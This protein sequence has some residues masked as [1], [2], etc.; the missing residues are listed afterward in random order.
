DEIK[1]LKL[2]DLEFANEVFTPEGEAVNR[3]AAK[4]VRAEARAEAQ[5]RWRKGRRR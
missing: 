1:R 4:A 2:L 5:E 3:G